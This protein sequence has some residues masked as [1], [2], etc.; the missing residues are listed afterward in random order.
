[1]MLDNLN[2]Q[3]GS[4]KEKKRVGRGKT[5]RGKTSGRGHKGQRSR[6]GGSVSP[7]FEGGQ[8]PLKLRSLKRGFNNPNRITYDVVNINKLNIF[9]GSD[10]ITTQELKKAGL[11]SGRNPV[12]ILGGGELEK[13]LD[14]KANGFSKAA[15]KKIEEKGGKAEII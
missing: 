4:K 5:N 7:W 14:V 6:S 13:T 2:P 10:Q 15:I 3:I 12:K 8:T 11:V 9:D 1:M